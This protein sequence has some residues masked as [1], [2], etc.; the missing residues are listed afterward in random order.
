VFQAKVKTKKP[1]IAQIPQMIPA[2]EFGDD[3]AILPASSTQEAKNGA[4]R[5]SARDFW[6]FMNSWILDFPTS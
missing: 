6:F 4:M 3:R 2:R 1:Q 5:N